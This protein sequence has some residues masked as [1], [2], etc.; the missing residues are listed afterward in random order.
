MSLSPD[1]SA[2]ELPWHRNALFYGTGRDALRALLIYGQKKMG[3]T[4]LLMP[5]YFCQSV[6]SSLLSTGIKI[7]VYRDGPEIPAPEFDNIQF[8]KGDLLLVVNYFGLRTQPSYP[9]LPRDKIF[10]VENHTHDPLS[11]WAK[12]SNADWCFASLRKSLPIPDGAVLWSPIGNGLPPEPRLSEEHMRASLEKLAA[13]SLKALYLEGLFEDKEI[14]RTLTIAGNKRI[15]TGEVSAMSD[16]SRAMLER[17]PFLSW[18]KRR[19]D[20]HRAL[21]SELSGLSWV[22]VLQPP[23]D[24]DTCP[25]SAVLLFDSPERRDF[26]RERLIEAR[27]YPAI[28]WSLEEPVVSGISESNL[29]FSRRMLSIHC[30]M[31][32]DKK[33]MLRVAE[34]IQQAGADFGNG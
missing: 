16:W 1:D 30:D 31:R 33:D 3:W 11:F 29:D 24:G 6:V 12:T 8:Q 5:S 21:S 22:R 7:E 32:Y 17:F 27:V 28:L 20:N 19:K 13:M 2:I 25:F 18:R 10:I 26:V 23:P 34:I 15:G 9:Q 4:R 14:F